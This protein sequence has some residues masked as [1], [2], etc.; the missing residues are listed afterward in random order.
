MEDFLKQGGVNLDEA[1]EQEE[2]K[3]SPVERPSELP[4]Q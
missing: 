1:E 4:P 3:A 2:A